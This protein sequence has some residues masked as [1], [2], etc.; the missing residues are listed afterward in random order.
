VAVSDRARAIRAARPSVIPGARAIRATSP[1]ANAPAGSSSF[2]SRSAVFAPTPGIDSSSSISIYGS[3]RRPTAKSHRS[4]LPPIRVAPSLIGITLSPVDIPDP[5]RFLH[6]H[7]LINTS[8]HRHRLF[9]N[10]SAGP[11]V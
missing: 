2:D 5:S 1:S 9:I 11:T 10:T 7:P 3:L 6:L 4:L 8:T